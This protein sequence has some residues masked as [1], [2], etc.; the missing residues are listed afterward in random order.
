MEYGT[1][2][3][4]I[5]IARPNRFIAHVAFS[6]G[7][8]VCHVKNTGRCQELLVPGCTVYCEKADNPNRKTEWDLIAAEKDGRLFNLDSSA[9][10]RVAGEWIA[11]GGFLPAVTKIRPETTFSKSRFDFYVETETGQ[12]FLE[13]KGV[14]LEEQNLAL[15]P[16]AP[17]LRGLKHIE[18]LIAA[19]KVGFGAHLLFVI[20]FEGAVG[21][22]PNN[23]TQP[24]FGD[25]LKRAQAAGVSVLAMDCSVQPSRLTLQS[26]VEVLL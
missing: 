6:F 3:R 15:F 1:V 20:Q 4:G 17:T 22:S 14:T 10:N 18:E 25:A 12:H 16:D 7:E 13:V 5:F 11:A 19:K 9:P 21:F 2:E 8:G 24:A 26:P 23:R